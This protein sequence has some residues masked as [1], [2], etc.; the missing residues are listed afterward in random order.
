MRSDSGSDLPTVVI[1][2]ERMDDEPGWDEVGVGELVHVGP[3]LVVEREMIL[4]HPPSHPMVLRGRAEKS[5]SY[6][7]DD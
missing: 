6:E 4:D 7:R 3:D 1:A 2:S 5:Q